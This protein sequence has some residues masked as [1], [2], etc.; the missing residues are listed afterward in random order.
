MLDN[1]GSGAP[2]SFDGDAFGCGL[3]SILSLNQPGGF[4]AHGDGVYGTGA[5]HGHGGGSDV[6]FNREYLGR[7]QVSAT[8][9]GVCGDAYGGGS[10][11]GWLR[12]RIGIL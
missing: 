7:E 12:A 4:N 1:E 9:D 5:G 6:C 2:Y 10:G 11:C 3:D 8:G